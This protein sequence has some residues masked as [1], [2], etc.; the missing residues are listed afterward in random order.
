MKNIGTDLAIIQTIIGL[1]SLVVA[2][3]GIIGVPKLYDMWKG[4]G[5][6]RILLKKLSRGPFD[7]EVIKRSTRYFIRPECQNLDPA[8]EVDL[9]DALVH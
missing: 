3:V 5:S 6:R 2:I 7:E 1:F 4:W 8:Q 9:R